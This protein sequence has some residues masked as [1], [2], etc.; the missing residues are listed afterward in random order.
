MLDT[1]SKIDINSEITPLV[2]ILHDNAKEIKENLKYTGDLCCD[3]C[4][5][6]IS[7]G[8]YYYD[9]LE[10][11]K[12]CGPQALLA[13]FKLIDRT[14]FC[15]HCKPIK[16]K[17]SYCP[18]VMGSGHAWYNY[19][20]IDICKN[21]YD[22]EILA[23]DIMYIDGTDL[24]VNE[25]HTKFNNKIPT[26]LIIP[27]NLDF[28]EFDFSYDID[29]IVYCDSKVQNIFDWINT[30]ANDIDKEYDEM[31]F[32]LV[33][34]NPESARY[35]SV[36]SGVY[37]N[38]GRT[39]INVVFDDIADFIKAHNTWKNDICINDPEE[40]DKLRNSICEEHTSIYEEYDA[41]LCKTFDGYVR[42]INKLGIYYG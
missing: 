7:E 34:C 39:A 35:G 41:K 5:K 18:M 11:C 32:F 29:N 42:M 19:D 6:D 14:D 28:I 30:V 8:M 4:Q 16:W 10:I 20:E 33:N 26:N 36:A 21:C 40:Y 13:Q 24:M 38:H 27:E 23:R 25:R 9:Q 17:C 22:S 15:I 31:A 3:N 37:D 12:D 1:F 2:K